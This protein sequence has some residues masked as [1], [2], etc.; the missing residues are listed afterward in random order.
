LRRT[1]TWNARPADS[2]HRPVGRVR[3][4][5]RPAG[6]G[7]GHECRPDHLALT[8]AVHVALSCVTTAAGQT[9]CTNTSAGFFAGLGVFVVVYLAILV[10]SIVAAVRW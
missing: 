5:G 6:G 7:G 10:I 4:P 3:P 9:V 8:G 2:T 1:R